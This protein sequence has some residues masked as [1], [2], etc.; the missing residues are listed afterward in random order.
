M[1]GIAVVVLGFAVRANPVLVVMV[2]AITTGVAARLEPVAL[3]ELIGGSFLKNRYLLIFVITLPVI[4]LVEKHGLREHA[5]RWITSIRVA[6]ASRILLAYLLVRQ[7]S[8]AAGLTSL[9]GQAQTVRPLLAPM[10]EAAAEK[11][12]GPLPAGTRDRL[13][14]LCAGTDNIALFFGEDIF[15]AFSAVLLIQS[16]YREGGITLEPLHI[17]LQ[18][19][20]T[21]IAAFAIHATRLWRLD[22]KLAREAAASIQ[23]LEGERAP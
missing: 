1:L 18:G 5:R 21:A 13:K 12:H 20:P 3:L 7:G 10:A 14:A 15:L 2:A 8:A 22:R 11:V 4:G 19:I 16:F 23:I 6:T 9:G 17:A